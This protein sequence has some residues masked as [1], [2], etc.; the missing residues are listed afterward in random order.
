MNPRKNKAVKNILRQV[1]NFQTSIILALIGLALIGAGLSISKLSSNSEEPQF[2]PASQQTKSEE[3]IMIDVEGAVANPGVYSLKI[4]SRVNDAIDAAGGL[5]KKADKDWVSRNINLVAKLADGQ[6]IYV[7]K[8]GETS[9]ATSQPGKVSG[10]ISSK[11]SINTA[12]EAELDSLPGIGPVR[13]GKIIANRPYKSIE[14]LRSKK[15]LGEAT[16]EKV[17]DKVTL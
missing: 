13:A 12:T 4:G 2:V 6:K 5:A 14:E 10:E 16:F 3:K 8:K 1:K 9:V 15:V 11:I 7:P 17:K